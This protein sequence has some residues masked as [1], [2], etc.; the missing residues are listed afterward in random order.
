MHAISSY[1]GHRP[2]HKHTSKQTKKHTH[3]QDRLQYTA[4]LSLARS[5]TRMALSSAHTSAKAAN[6]AKSLPLNKRPVQQ[7]SIAGVTRPP[8]HANHNLNPNVP[9]PEYHQYLIVSS[10]WPTCLLFIAFCENWLNRILKHSDS[11]KL[12]QG[13]LIIRHVTC[14]L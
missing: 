13:P 9:D 12:R 6:P 2:T 3:R 8:P 11:T 10:S 14:K 4:P 5:V 1:R 7:P